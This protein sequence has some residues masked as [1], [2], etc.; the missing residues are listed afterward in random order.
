MEERVIEKLV[1]K[2]RSYSVELWKHSLGVFN[3]SLVLACRM[4]LGAGER[5]N[6][7]IGALLHDLGKTRISPAIINKAG[8]LAAEEWMEV[9]LHPGYGAGIL[10]GYGCLQAVVPLVLYHHERW[11]R[12]GYL[13]RRGT[14]TPLGAR[15]IAVADAIDA[16]TSHRPYRKAKGMREVVR[17]LQKGRSSQFDPLLV[18]LV[19]AGRQP[20]GHS[21]QWKRAGQSARVCE[22]ENWPDC[23]L[24][25]YQDISNLLVYGWDNFLEQL[26]AF[27][28]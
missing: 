18:D 2:V 9:K 28:R 8:Q 16:M 10:A 1:E 23:L 15:V 26:A 19:L 20:A 5:K 4:Q 21:G 6:I 14:E 7:A 12:R 25:T 11:D 3:I 22:K 13:G 24:K 17:E 27:Q